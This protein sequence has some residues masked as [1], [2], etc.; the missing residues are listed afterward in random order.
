[1]DLRQKFLEAKFD[2]DESCM[3]YLDTLHRHHRNDILMEMATITSKIKNS[4]R[5]VQTY[6]NVS[7][8]DSN[9]FFFE[10]NVIKERG[11]APYFLKVSEI[12]SDDYLDYIISK[13]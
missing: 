12:T 11:Y 9:S 5:E 6:M 2:M 10:I 1:M 7:D 3:E 8:R 13:R 4:P